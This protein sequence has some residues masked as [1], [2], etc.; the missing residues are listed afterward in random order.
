MPTASFVIALLGLIAAISSLAWQAAT[1]ILSGIRLDCNMLYGAI[2]SGRKI[3]TYPI[4]NRRLGSLDTSMI[5]QG[6]TTEAIFLTVHNNGRL[7]FSVKNWHLAL[8]GGVRTGVLNNPFGPTLPHRLD[9]G[10]EATWAMELEETMHVVNMFRDQRGE[11]PIP[12]W[13][14]VQ[15]GNGKTYKSKQVADI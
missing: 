3:A 10:E 12:A 8:E 11:G 14:E 15:V 5:A 1:F 2:S 4:K 13:I 7:P 6:F 9:V